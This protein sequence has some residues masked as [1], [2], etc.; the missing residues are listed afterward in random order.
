MSDTRYKIGKRAAVGTYRVSVDKRDAGYIYRRHGSWYA[1]V[2]GYLAESRHTTRYDA[3]E[4]LVILHDMGIKPGP[5]P[6]PAPAPDGLTDTAARYAPDLKYTLPNFVRAAEAM[7]RIAELGWAPIKGYPGADQPWFMECRLCGWRGHRFWSHLRG[8]NND[9]TPRPRS[10]HE[11]CIP[12]PQH[13]EKIA[14]VTADH[15]TECTCTFPH[16]TTPTEC[17]QVLSLLRS[18]LKN[19]YGA[20]A[21]VYVRAIL[22][23]CPAASTRA[24][25]LRKAL[26]TLSEK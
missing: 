4:Q 5:V 25:S 17:G 16:A 6:A 9:R 12:I 19:K 2:P 8:R 14:Q 3:A 10:R 11:D 21:S 23:P 26:E 15:A 22:E 1:V 20:A 18:A 13:A 24:V 7:A